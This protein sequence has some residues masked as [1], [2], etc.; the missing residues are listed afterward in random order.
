MIASKGFV[1]AVGSDFEGAE[2]EVVG[3]GDEV[4]GLTESIRDI[5]FV[6]DASMDGAALD[7]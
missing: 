4:V 2:V 5:R 7:D 6:V 1:E 3:D